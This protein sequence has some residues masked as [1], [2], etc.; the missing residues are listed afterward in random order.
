MGAARSTYRLDINHLKRLVPVE[1]VV[2]YVG[3]IISVRREP[4]RLR[5]GS[6][7]SMMGTMDTYYGRSIE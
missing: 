5:S 2:V 7:N 3:A 4:I 6:H 1:N